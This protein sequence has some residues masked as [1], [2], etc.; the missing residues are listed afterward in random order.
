MTTTTDTPTTAARRATAYQ[1]AGHVVIAWALG[2]EVFDAS[3]FDKVVGDRIG[4]TGMFP[5]AF[6]DEADRPNMARRHAVAAYAG[7][8]AQVRATG[9]TDPDADILL[10]VRDDL[11]GADAELRAYAGLAGRRGRASFGTVLARLTTP[12]VTA[13]R[14]EAAALVQTHRPVV[15]TVAERKLSREALDALRAVRFL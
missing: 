8:Y 3:L 5:P 6:Y 7:Y 14:A 9:A 13:L 15:T 2:L 4:H 1:E 12:M 10:S 11:T